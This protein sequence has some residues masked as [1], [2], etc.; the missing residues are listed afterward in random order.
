MISQTSRQRDNYVLMFVSIL[1]LLK[2]NYW[3]F[4]F[5]SDFKHT[6]IFIENE[7]D[8]REITFSH[9]QNIR[10]LKISSF[11]ICGAN[12]LI[13]LHLS[14]SKSSGTLLNK[15]AKKVCIL[16]WTLL[17]FDMTEEVRCYYYNRSVQQIHHENNLNA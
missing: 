13:T 9:N 5:I 1:T 11:N 4:H 6:L 15:I 16:D 12:N 7:D 10:H 8:K 14:T 17:Y 2:Q 3:Y